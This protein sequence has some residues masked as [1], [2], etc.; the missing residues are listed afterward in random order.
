MKL[1]HSSDH[2]QN[3]VTAKSFP[4]SAWPPR[5][6]ETALNPNRQMGFLAKMAMRYPSTKAAFTLLEVMIAMSVIAIALVA[7]LNLQAQGMALAGE[8]KFDTT[9]SLLAQ[10]KLAEIEALDIEDL[11]SDSGDF[12]DDFPLYSWQISADEGTLSTTQDLSPYL[13]E[14]ELE[15]RWKDSEAYGYRIKFYRFSPGGA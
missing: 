14:I 7:A 13:R 15:I 4:R 8:S 11:R 6:P 3:G 2:P 5:R 9:A 12:G 1:N 10:M